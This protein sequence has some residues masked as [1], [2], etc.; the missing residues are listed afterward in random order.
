MYGYNP[1]LAMPITVGTAASNVATVDANANTLTLNDNSSLSGPGQLAVI[2]SLGGGTVVLGGTYW[3]SG[4]FIVNAYS[5]GTKVLSGTLEVV[6]SQALPKTGVLTVAGPG[7]IV[8]SVPAGT[9]FGN[10]A[11][12]QAVAV[13]SMSMDIAPSA[14]ATDASGSPVPALIGAAAWSPWRATPRRSPS[15]RCWPCWAPA[16]SACSRLPGDGERRPRARHVNTGGWIEAATG[17]RAKVFR[18]RCPRPIRP[19]CSM[20]LPAGCH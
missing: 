6:N 7:A 11:T 13:G 19:D 5:G 20:G 2:D 9:L 12:G 10:S 8:S 3:N 18:V 17:L 15:L 1:T 16:C 4:A 14:T